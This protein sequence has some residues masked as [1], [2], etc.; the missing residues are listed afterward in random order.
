MNV[1]RHSRQYVHMHVKWRNEDSWALTVIYG[2]PQRALRQS[3]WENLS[4]ISNGMSYPWCAVGDF[5]A[6][7][8]ASEK[9]GSRTSSSSST[10]DPFKIVC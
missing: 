7:L 4:D 10:C 9:G 3:L 2:S 1:Q 8:K 6:I 5:N